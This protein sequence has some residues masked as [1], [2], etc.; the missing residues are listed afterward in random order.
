LKMTGHRVLDGQPSS[1]AAGDAEAGDARP[2]ELARR[3]RAQP[4]PR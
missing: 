4:P 3:H 1:H 2:L